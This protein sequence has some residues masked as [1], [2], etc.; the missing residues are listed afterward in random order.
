VALAIWN[1]VKSSNSKGCDCFPSLTM[2]VNIFVQLLIAI[3]LPF[4]PIVG[5]HANKFHQGIAGRLGAASL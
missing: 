2:T 1:E 3:F 5:C 4:S